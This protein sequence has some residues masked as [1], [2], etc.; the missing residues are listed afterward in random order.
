MRT[1]FSCRYDDMRQPAFPVT[2]QV[3]R[4]GARVLGAVAPQGPFARNARMQQRLSSI[5]GTEAGTLHDGFI[6]KHLR[7]V[8]YSI[9]FWVAN[10][11]NVGSN[12]IVVPKGRS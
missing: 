5:R 3:E 12:R 2:N 8:E 11:D 6:N 1:W 7:A 9:G 10:N 4:L